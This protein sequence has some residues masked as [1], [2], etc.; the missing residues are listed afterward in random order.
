MPRRGAKS[1]QGCNQQG[2]SAAAADQATGR[3]QTDCRL[4][5]SEVDRAT[6]RCCPSVV[7]VAA[8]AGAAVVAR[9][10]GEPSRRST[11]DPARAAAARPLPAWVWASLSRVAPA[12]T[13]RSLYLTLYLTWP[14]SSASAASAATSNRPSGCRCWQSRSPA[15]AA[16]CPLPAPAECPGR[17]PAPLPETPGCDPPAASFSY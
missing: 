3:R 1:N 7:V 11:A 10:R 15:A 5:A 14:R 8:A 12:G 17:R 16:D 2:I 4:V 13:L 9:A 6:A